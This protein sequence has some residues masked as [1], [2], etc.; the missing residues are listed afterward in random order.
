MEGSA[1]EEAE[2]AGRHPK[3]IAG[4]SQ[5]EVGPEQLE[6]TGGK[7]SEKNLWPNGTRTKITAGARP[8]NAR[9]PDVKGGPPLHQLLNGAE[10]HRDS[11]G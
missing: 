2:N 11:Q 1:C 10:T 6:K 4:G 5:E 8:T 9:P 7:A 3:T